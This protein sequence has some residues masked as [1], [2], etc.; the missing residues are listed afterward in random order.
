V[1]INLK[2]YN[3]E[4]KRLN[5][6][7]LNSKSNEAKA[8][9]EEYFQALNNYLQD[10]E[11]NKM[12]NKDIS[13]SIGYT[14]VPDSIVEFALSYTNLIEDDSEKE[15]AFSLLF[16]LA[17]NFFD[18]AYYK[19]ALSLFDIAKMIATGKQKIDCTLSLALLYEEIGDISKALSVLAEEVA[20]GRRLS[21]TQKEFNSKLHTLSARI[22][23]DNLTSEND[24]NRRN[25]ADYYID[26]LKKCT[27]MIEIAIIQY[28]DNYEAFYIKGL[29]YEKQALY[30][31]DAEAGSL[32]EK[33]IDEISLLIEDIGDED[34]T[35]K[36]FYWKLLY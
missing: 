33:A 31:N 19:T 29:I 18:R 1:S 28:E 27:T 35:E 16:S 21:I 10:K 22:T 15:T 32:Y 7:I 14:N 36:N 17:Q 25:P 4:I 34:A 5:L 9:Y 24:E 12:T 11:D 13:D 23:L 20:G 8:C 3:C 2:N 30:S 26:E 6:A